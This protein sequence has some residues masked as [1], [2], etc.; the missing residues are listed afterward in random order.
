MDFS[1]AFDVVPHNRLLSK[2]NHYGVQNKTLAWIS[3]FLKDRTQKALVSGEKSSWCDVLSG[4]S[5]GTVLG[6]LLFLTYINDLRKDIQSTVRLF[7]DDCVIYREIKNEL[8]AQMLQE[9]LNTLE[10]WEKTWLIK[11][12][13][14]KCF[15]HARS[16]KSH[17]YTLGGEHCQKHR[18]THTW[19]YA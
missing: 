11:F 8:D 4:V 6:P 5:Q 14:K 10:K 7:A 16:T 12:N 19:E 1:K 15:T 3:A 13:I 18:A 17:V 9:D 2:L